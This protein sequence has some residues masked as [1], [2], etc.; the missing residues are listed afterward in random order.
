MTRIVHGPVMS[1]TQAFSYNAIATEVLLRHLRGT[2]ATK[3]SAK[4]AMLLPSIQRSR[5]KR[6]D[7]P[8]PTIIEIEL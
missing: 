2:D 3:S 7:L 1:L 8:S 6:T 5:Q 4:S